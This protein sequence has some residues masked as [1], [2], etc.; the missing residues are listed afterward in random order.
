MQSNVVSEFGGDP[1]EQSALNLLYPLARN[2]PRHLDPL[3]GYDEMLHIVGGND[4]IVSGMVSQL[5]VG[6][7]RQGYELVAL[8][9]ARARLPRRR[10]A[11]TA[12][13]T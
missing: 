5:P 8:R 2:K 3:P 7:I 11:R 4:Q 13:H 10:S 1:G 9:A 12:A 6:T